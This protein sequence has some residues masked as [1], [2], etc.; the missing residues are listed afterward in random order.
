MKPL[1]FDIVEIER[2]YRSGWTMDKIASHIG[3]TKRSVA[4]YLIRANV[5]S[6]GHSERYGIEWRSRALEKMKE[7][8]PDLAYLMGYTL[9]DGS[10]DVLNPKSPGMSYGCISSDACLLQFIV[11]F[12]GLDSKIESCKNGTQV[13]LRFF[14]TD[15]V[16]R[17]K[18]LGMMPRKTW[19]DYG[20]PEMPSQFKHDFIRGQF[21]GNGCAS[22]Y[23]DRFGGCIHF[24][25]SKSIVTSIRDEVAKETSC[26]ETPIRP[27][28]GHFA[29]VYQ[30]QKDIRKIY[31]YMYP[32]GHGM[33]LPRKKSKVEDILSL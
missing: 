27:R 5:P 6:R 13:R 30:S 14:G 33:F 24:L 20:F 2:L 9:A 7:W 22:K 18:E 3:G 23:K 16:E 31:D 4:N 21:D 32:S 25:G 11:D 19:E 15:V 28:P 1:K 8:S 10:M 26:K 12:L 29:A 17:F